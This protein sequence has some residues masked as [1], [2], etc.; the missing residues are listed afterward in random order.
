MFIIV[1]WTFTHVVH[2]SFLN[3]N[4]RIKSYLS[5]SAQ[6]HKEL[7]RVTES[8][9]ESSYHVIFGFSVSSL[10]HSQNNGYHKQTYGCFIKTIK[11]TDL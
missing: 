11:Q 5:V 8:V 4:Q 6:G 7:K 2:S 10:F 3:I 1:V 9:N